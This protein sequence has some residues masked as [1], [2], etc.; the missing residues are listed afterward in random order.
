[1]RTLAEFQ[2][3]AAAAGISGPDIHKRAVQLFGLSA[4]TR[5]T[6]YNAMAASRA[7]TDTLE[8]LDAA[9]DSLLSERQPAHGAA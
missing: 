1:M 4:P 3:A 2:E 6:V 8:A 9:L 7:H 5:Q